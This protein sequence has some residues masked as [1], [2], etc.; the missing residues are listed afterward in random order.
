MFTYILHIVAEDTVLWII[1]VMPFSTAL[2]P[3][4]LKT[5]YLIRICSLAITFSSI[6]L[7]QSIVIVHTPF[8]GSNDYA[9]MHKYFNFIDVSK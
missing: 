3:H 2:C 7:S 6:F 4:I 5:K 1:I 9:N 8:V